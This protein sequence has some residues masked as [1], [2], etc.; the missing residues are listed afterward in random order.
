MSCF[1][2]LENILQEF[3]ND[4]GLR[5]SQLKIQSL[6]IPAIRFTYI[7]CIIFLKLFD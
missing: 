3:S 7:D 4:S 2:F 6:N 5:D 1:C